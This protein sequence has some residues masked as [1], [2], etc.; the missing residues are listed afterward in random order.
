[1]K[2][3]KILLIL[4]CS[5]SIFSC[6]KNSGSSSSVV[7]TSPSV[8]ELTSLAN[9]FK[10]DYNGANWNFPIGFQPASYMNG[11]NSS[12]TVI[13]VCEVYSDGS[14][15][16][17]FNDSW[18]NTST[19]SSTAKKLLFYHELGH[20]FFNRAHDSRT[21]ADGHPYTIMNPV[22]DPVLFYYNSGFSAYYI[23]E[24]GSPMPMMANSTNYQPSLQPAV[25]VQNYSTLEDGSCQTSNSN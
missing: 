24:L 19:T 22:I 17:W 8:D 21:Y 15:K 11:G 5:I 12:L 9:S 1:M 20:C 14:K 13:G 7:P 2:T 23:T 6:S 4:V 18:W 10:G 16:V 3:K 25:M